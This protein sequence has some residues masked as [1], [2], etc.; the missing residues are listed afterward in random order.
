MTTMPKNPKPFLNTLIGK[1]VIVKLKWGQEYRGDL[2]STDE[3][4]N[5]Q[6]VNCKEFIRGKFVDALGE[7]MIRNNNILYIRGGDEK[8]GEMEI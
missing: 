4:L 2:V 8:V 7:V 6:L 3:Y 5:V 1:F